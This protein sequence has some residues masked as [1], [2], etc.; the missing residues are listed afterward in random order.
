MDSSSSIFVRY[1]EKM[2][3]PIVIKIII[4]KNDE[5]IIPKAFGLGA[6]FFNF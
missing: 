4:V 1:L 6:A 2:V 3:E 5:K